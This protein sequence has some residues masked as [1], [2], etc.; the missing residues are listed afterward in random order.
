MGFEVFEQF[1]THLPDVIVYP[2]GGGTGLVG[3]WKAFDELEQLGWIDARRP[4]MVSVQ[5]EGCA[6][7][8]KAFE[9]GHDATSPWEHAHTVASGLRVPVPFAGKLILRAIRESGGTAVAVTDDEI[10]QSQVELA[11]SEGLLAAPEGAATWAAVKKLRA[12]GWLD[13]EQRVVL[14][15]TGAGLKYL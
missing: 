4:R 10:L 1:D 12:V 5:A 3:M 9:K 14:F 11:R 7:I 2:T 8:V 6:P 15:N 13:P